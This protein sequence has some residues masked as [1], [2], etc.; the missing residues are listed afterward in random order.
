MVP[1]R[2]PEELLLVSNDAVHGEEAYALGQQGEVRGGDATL[3]HDAAAADR[4]VEPHDRSR[5]PS[6]VDYSLIN[7]KYD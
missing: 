3:P 6:N 4:S 1:L 7:D 2:I 5:R